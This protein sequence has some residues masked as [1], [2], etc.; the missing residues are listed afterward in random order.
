MSVTLQYNYAAITADT[1][2]CMS[3]FTA[4]DRI[5][6]PTYIEVPY[7]TDDYLLKYYNMNGDKRWYH[8]GTFTNLWV[9]CP[10]HNV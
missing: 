2:Q 8:N 4:S 6:L 1:F 10:S 3:C 7:A 5:D 9:E